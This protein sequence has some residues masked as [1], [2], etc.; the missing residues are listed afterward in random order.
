[1]V[2]RQCDRRTRTLADQN[3]DVIEVGSLLPRRLHKVQ[4]SLS[5]S[6]IDSF[7]AST[8]LLIDRA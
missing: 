7:V 6:Q 4:S 8:F 1:M 2:P 5:R 3:F